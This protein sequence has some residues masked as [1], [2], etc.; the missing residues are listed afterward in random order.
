MSGFVRIVQI[1][2]LA[3]TLLAGCA[4]PRAKAWPHP[5]T[6]RAWLVADAEA[7]LGQALASPFEAVPAQGFSSHEARWERPTLAWLDLA[8]DTLEREYTAPP[9][10]ARSLAL[11]A[12]ALHDS[13]V[14]V[15]LA[16]ARG[17]AASSDAALAVAASRTLAH[18]HPLRAELFVEAAHQAR[19]S[20]F[21]QGRD[22]AA[23]ALGER[24]GALVAARLITHARHDGAEALAG[25][26]QPAPTRAAGRWQ[27]TPPDYWSPLL[28]G[29]G[30]VATLGVG[31][32]EEL[33]APAPPA[34]DSPAMAAQRA[35]FAETQR[36]L[37]EHERA[38]A[39]HWAAGPGTVTPAG[40]WFE[41]ARA[42]L[43][44][45]GLDDQ[46]SAAVLAT[47]GVAMHDAFI[48]CW[49]SK[50]RYMLA[51][52]IQWMQ[53]QDPAWRPV[54]ATP[55]FPAYPS[56][57][58]CAS[59]AAARV[60]AIFFPA[61]AYRLNAQASEAAHSRVLAGLHW[62]IDSQAGL[63]LGRRAADSALRTISATR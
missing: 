60:L 25:S 61:E 57:H 1:F 44:R 62:P 21:T 33:L 9:Q 19:S 63:A 28:P 41:I 56:G 34:W 26:A 22:S 59:G 4:L 48:G 40:M 50:Y 51:R 37:T 49:L 45:D 20:S 17:H 53:G 7:L 43:V 24:L 14:L 5:S 18:L 47:L 23:L 13:Q 58:A 52:P 42:L 36:R 3:A 30:A 31:S 39:R 29:W 32:V 15:A 27:P 38:L 10:A 6:E 2:L 55:P 12:V 16:R 35:R 46:Q 54:I 8:L 11:L